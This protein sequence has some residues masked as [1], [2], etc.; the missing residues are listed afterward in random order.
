MPI[1]VYRAT[2]PETSCDS[3][4]EEFEV[5][6]SMK[7]DSLTKCGDCEAPIEKVP[8]VPGMAFPKGAAALRNMGMA[9]LEKR[10]DGKYENVS[11]QDGYQKVGSLESF[12]KDL[13]KG[14]KKVISD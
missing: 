1:Y 12:S 10:S 13:A 6:Q 9:R 5:L 7:D 14:P 3:C 11:A 2:D 8:V 4:R